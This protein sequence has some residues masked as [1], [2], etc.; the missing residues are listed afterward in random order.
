MAEVLKIQES[1]KLRKMCL[2]QR[3]KDENFTKNVSKFDSD[4]NFPTLD[5]FTGAKMGLVYLHDT[6]QFDLKM[7]VNGT[8]ST[9]SGLSFCSEHKLQFQDFYQ[10]TR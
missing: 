9:K 4:Q 7:L 1:L 6:Y 8:I 2:V 3:D 10:L 5:E